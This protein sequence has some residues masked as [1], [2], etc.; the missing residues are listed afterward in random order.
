M[1]AP[2]KSEALGILGD[3]LRERRRELSLSQEAL[4]VRADL[5]WS[6]IGQV[7]RGQRDFGVQN[8]LK[9]AKALQVEPGELVNGLSLPD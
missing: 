4:A 1:A 5:H 2:P 8:L 7:E 6:Y 3:R 9:L